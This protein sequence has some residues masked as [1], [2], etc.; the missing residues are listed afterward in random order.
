MPEQPL[1]TTGDLAKVLGV[2]AGTVRHYVREG[3]I[4]ATRTTLGGHRRFVLGDVVEELR[5]QGVHISVIEE[6]TPSNLSVDMG[7][8]RERE[9][10]MSLGERFPEPGESAI[11][12]GLADSGSLPTEITALAGP[13][14]E[15]ADV[16]YSP[17]DN[18]VY[19]HLRRWAGP[20]VSPEVGVRA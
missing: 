16:T 5:G 1:L 6:P 3:K 15:N 9:G 14:D 20:V 4:H 11:T 17:D 13:V 2:A 7:E 19:E 8:M 10:I 18:P 12:V